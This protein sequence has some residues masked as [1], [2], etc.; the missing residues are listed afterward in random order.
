[1][2]D[3]IKIPWFCILRPS[4]TLVYL[5][6]GG[7]QPNL[8]KDPC[9]QPWV[10]SS[11]GFDI[12]KERIGSGHSHYF[13]VPFGGKTTWF[14]GPQVITVYP[15]MPFGDKFIREDNDSSRKIGVDDLETGPAWG[16]KD[17]PS[18]SGHMEWRRCVTVSKSDLPEMWIWISLLKPWSRGGK[19]EEALRVW[20]F[21]SEL[22]GVCVREAQKT[23]RLFC[24]NFISPQVWKLKPA[25][26]SDGI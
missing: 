24:S 25:I 5:V 15:V 6:R 8:I 12:I 4:W 17:K 7:N 14:R 20:R 22:K 18:S 16:E 19:E 9:R 3:P 13:V 2:M 23:R 21:L 11:K 10:A 1:M 26:E